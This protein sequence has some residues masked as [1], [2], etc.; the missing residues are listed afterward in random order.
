MNNYEIIYIINPQEQDLE[1]IK[2][3]LLEMLNDPKELK[4]NIWGLKKFAYPIKKHDSGHYIQINCQISGE[5]AKAL[6]AKLNLTKS[7]L[8]Y[9]IVNLDNEKRFRY[10]TK[11]WHTKSFKRDS[12]PTFSNRKPVSTYKSQT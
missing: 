4:V 11:P 9:L 12:N 8:R 6:P 2:A 5:T 1:K 7:V 10:K 3:S